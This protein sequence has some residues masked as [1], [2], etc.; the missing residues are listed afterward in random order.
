M[1]WTVPVLLAASL[2]GS[3]PAPSAKSGGELPRARVGVVTRDGARH[4]VE[5]EIAATDAARARGLMHRRE[6]PASRGMLFVFERDEDH[7]FWMRNTF[8]PLDMI[9]AAEDG[10]IVGIVRDARPET[11]TPRSVGRPSRYVLEVIGGWAAERGVKPGDRLVLDEVKAR[12]S[13]PRGPVRSP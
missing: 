3:A 5:V 7:T 4:T 10:A 9:F 8:L 1:R 13:A 12:L 11:D 2:C 6:L